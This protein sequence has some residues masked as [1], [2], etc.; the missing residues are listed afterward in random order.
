MEVKTFITLNWLFEKYQENPNGV[1]DISHCINMNSEL[2]VNQVHHLGKHLATKGYVKH[3][4]EHENGFTCA[5]TTLGIIQV[6][7]VLNEVKYKILHASI[8]E[9]KSSVM[10]ILEVDPFHFKKA[11]DYATYL[12]RMGIIECIFANNDVFAKP[13]FY[14]REWY[15]ANKQVN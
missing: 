5:I 2:E 6:S 9:Q 10:E 1:W 12:K 8:E 7:N 11:Y 14:G 3:Q 13:T 15:E 4:Q